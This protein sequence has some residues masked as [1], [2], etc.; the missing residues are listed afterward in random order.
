MQV[1]SLWCRQTAASCIVGFWCD[2]SIAVACSA[3]FSKLRVSL[4]AGGFC[5]AF[6]RVTRQGH[7]QGMS[8]VWQIPILGLVCHLQSPSTVA[9]CFFR[10]MWVA[11]GRAAIE[12]ALPQSAQ[13]P[14]GL[15]LMGAA[16][17]DSWTAHEAEQ[18]EEGLLLFG[19]DF[20]A[21]RKQFL[22]QR[23]TEHLVLYYYN[24]WKT[25]SSTRAQEWYQ[26]LEQV[27]CKAL[28]RHPRLLCCF[29]GLLADL[30]CVMLKSFCQARNL[31]IQSGL[32]LRMRQW[33]SSCIDSCCI[34]TPAWCQHVTVHGQYRVL[35]CIT[36]GNMRQVHGPDLRGITTLCCCCG[37]FL[38]LWC[39]TQAALL[40]HNHRKK[41]K[42]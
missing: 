20:P 40:H 7:K 11:L 5:A 4:L 1:L 8:P 10:V 33:Q 35:A 6:C 34:Y 22:P 24:V 29:R 39:L 3:R 26:R 31:A 18:F 37:S 28:G 14:L 25:Q 41:R 2:V 30:L 36:I 23:E 19:R 13:E 38:Q 21:I 17:G 27:C 9:C 42:G 15:A 16:V 32:Q 12:S